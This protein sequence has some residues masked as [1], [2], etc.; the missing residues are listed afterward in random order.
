MNN[1]IDNMCVRHH[2][3]Q[4]IKYQS[5]RQIRNQTR[6]VVWYPVYKNVQSLFFDHVLDI[7]LNNRQ[8]IYH[9]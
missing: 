3:R 5:F 4:N 7:I 1:L 2:I 9:E 8:D 6:G